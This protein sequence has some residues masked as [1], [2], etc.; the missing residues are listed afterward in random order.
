[1]APVSGASRVY[2]DF[3]VCFRAL[4]KPERGSVFLYTFHLGED[5]KGTGP[6]ALKS[7]APLAVPKKTFYP[8]NANTA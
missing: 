7:E 1:M 2:S 3:G 5:R 6:F 8:F 4:P